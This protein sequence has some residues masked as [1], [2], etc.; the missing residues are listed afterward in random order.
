MSVHVTIRSGDRAPI[1]S[2]RKVPCGLGTCE[3]G[4][5]GKVYS[6]DPGDDVVGTLGA[7][8]LTAWVLYQHAAS[9]SGVV[10]APTEPTYYPLPDVTHL[11]AAGGTSPTGP[12]I[13]IALRGEDGPFDDAPALTIRLSSNGALGAAM[14]DIAYDGSSFVESFVL[15]PERPAVLRGKVDLSGGYALES[16]VLAFTDPAAQSLTFPAGSYANGAEI[17]A[18]FNTLAEA[19]PLDVRA[20]IPDVAGG[21]EF[22]ELYTLDRGPSVSLTLDEG[23][24]TAASAL[25]FTTSDG[26]VDADGAPATRT[27]PRL[28]IVAT[29]ASGDYARG[30]TYTAPLQGPRS[31]VA[32]L[33]A[34]A[35]EAHDEFDLH[36]FGFFCTVEDFE[37]N[38]AAVTA[39]ATLE[40]SILEW[41]ADPDAPRFLDL[42]VGTAFHAASS[43]K[44]TNRT[45]I[46]AF[47]ADLLAAL[48]SSP[49]NFE[50]IAVDDVYLDGS[51][52]LL[53]GK[54]R[55][56]ASWAG[57]AK[58]AGAVKIAA[59]PADGLVPGASLLAADGLTRARD[60]AN[61]TTKLGKLAGP[62][63]WALKSTSGG[64]AAVKFAVCA[65]RAGATSRL[66]DPGVVA[67]ALEIAAVVFG[68]VEFYEGQTWET[69][70]LDPLAA[71]KEETDTRADHLRAV[72]ADF[73]TPKGQDPNVSNYNV[74]ISAPTVLNDGVA[75]VAIPFN[76][77]AVVGDVNVLI[78]PTGAVISASAA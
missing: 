13:S 56:S 16:L 32:A 70:P 53:P 48:A 18:A 36:P 6:F 3:L 43:N 45:A 41:R 52:E 20:R 72:L 31:S 11:D 7:G 17:A 75:N 62:G 71:A 24:G 4:E 12:A 69:D 77:L 76:P 15:P 10:A 57:A 28:G 68:E 64:L 44:A 63:F 51:A 49:A 47:D 65:T 34:A 33:A 61:A 19:A 40:Q 21:E 9:G 2:A 1:P 25:G 26:N 55:R 73:L 27:F 50:N 38:E 67:V 22:L 58:R 39:L 54:A 29:F 74:T 66:R 8:K 35:L 30:E 78:T 37:T 23:S 59:N 46:A 14:A 42:I 5:P 60:D